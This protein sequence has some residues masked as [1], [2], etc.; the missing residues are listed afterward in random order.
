[1]PAGIWHKSEYAKL[2]PYDA[3]TWQQP[4][5]VFMCHLRD[6]SIC[7]GWLLAHDRINLLALRVS[8]RIDPSVWD[9]A[10]DVAVFASG[11]E[12][13]AHG[14]SGCKKPS[15]AARRKMVGLVRLRLGGLNKCR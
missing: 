2:P 8:R 6:D 7:G 1:V 9:Y 3:P 15:A 12:A 5:G 13:A 4:L 11:A 14:V 10:P